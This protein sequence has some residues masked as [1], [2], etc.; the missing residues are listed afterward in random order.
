[1]L[2]FDVGGVPGASWEDA[3]GR[4][5]RACGSA[6]RAR[7]GFGINEG[8]CPAC[9]GRVAR[10]TGESSNWLGGGGRLAARAASALAERASRSVAALRRAA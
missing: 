5:C 1:M 7:D 9:S 3:S 6:I 2:R 4:W 10:I 8:V